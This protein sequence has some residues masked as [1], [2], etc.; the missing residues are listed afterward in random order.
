M[1]RKKALALRQAW[2]DQPCN[3]PTLARE[4]DQGERTGGYLC[5]QCGA[6]ISFRERA[7]LLASRGEKAD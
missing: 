2:G 5:A 3:H 7:E 6:T 4:Y 1:Q